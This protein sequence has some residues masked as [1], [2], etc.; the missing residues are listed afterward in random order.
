AQPAP[1]LPRPAT[2]SWFTCG[3]FHLSQRS[4]FPGISDESTRYL[5]SAGRS[6]LASLGTSAYGG[7]PVM[8]RLLPGLL[9]VLTLATAALTSSPPPA[10]AASTPPWLVHVQRFPGGLSAGVRQAAAAI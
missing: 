3:H 5:D 1:L 9:S 4:H 8:R 6:P 10:A 2:G 7:G